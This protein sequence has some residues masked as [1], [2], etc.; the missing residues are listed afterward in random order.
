MT[1]KQKVGAEDL[2]IINAALAKGA[3]VMIQNTA[4]GYRI[5]SSKITVL[6]RSQERQK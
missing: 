1:E 5:V 4:D 6:K 2:R 3:D